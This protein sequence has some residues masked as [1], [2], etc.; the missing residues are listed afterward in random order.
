MPDIIGMDC[1]K[2]LTKLGQ[3]IKNANVDFVGR[4]YRWPKSSYPSLTY[5]EAHALSTAGLK[6]VALWEWKSS[7]IDNFSY[8]EGLDQGTSAYKQAMQA[9]QPAGTPIYFAVDFDFSSSQIA[10]PISDYF[11]GVRAAFVAMGGGAVAYVIGVYGSGRSCDWL[12]SHGKVERTWLAMST[13]WA[14]YD[15]FT[16]FDIKQA[17][18]DLAIPSLKPGEKGDYD[19]DVARE[20]YGAFSVI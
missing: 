6:I 14:G 2:D 12:L 10:G 15:N 5:N 20:S 4:Y 1:A 17:G 7:Q 19:S 3:S 13:G 9:H 16:K 8:H 11:S 18:K